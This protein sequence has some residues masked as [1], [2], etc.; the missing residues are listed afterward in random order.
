MPS[1]LHRPALIWL[2]EAGGGRAA[3][4]AKRY[5]SPSLLA[6][7]AGCAAVEEAAPRALL[8]CTPW[9]PFR[10]QSSG[11]APGRAEADVY[12]TAPV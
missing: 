1:Q 6:S 7:D 2:P 8:T 10:V 3:N 11:W 4:L 9:V 12:P 5:S